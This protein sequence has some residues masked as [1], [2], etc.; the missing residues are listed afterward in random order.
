M[1]GPSASA[2]YCVRILRADGKRLG[3]TSSYSIYDADDSRRLMTTV[4]R[5]YPRP[6]L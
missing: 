3:F 4:V 6:T 5:E 2:P 1:Y